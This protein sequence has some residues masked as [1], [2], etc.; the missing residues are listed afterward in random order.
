VEICDFV[1]TDVDLRGFHDS[2]LCFS[3]EGN[4][5]LYV[6]TV[7]VAAFANLCVQSS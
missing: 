1:I 5:T 2:V 4:R 7:F 3:C 6:V